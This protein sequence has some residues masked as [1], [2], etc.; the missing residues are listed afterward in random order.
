MRKKLNR[1]PN[2]LTVLKSTDKHHIQR[3]LDLEKHPRQ[4]PAYQTGSLVPNLPLH[5]IV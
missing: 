2:V 1:R 4:K 5:L 3:I